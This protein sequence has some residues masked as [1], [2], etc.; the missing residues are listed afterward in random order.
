MNKTA[1]TSIAINPLLAERWSPR[2]FDASAEINN[3]DLLGLLE[4]A[5]WAPSASN[6]QPWRFAVG[7]RG[8]ETFNALFGSLAGFNSAWTP[9]ASALIL[10]AIE[11]VDAEGKPRRWAQYDAGLAASLLTVEAHTRNFH[12]H[13]MAGFDRDK[14]RAALGLNQTTEP[15]MILAIGKVAPAEQLEGPLLERETAPR[16]R[17]SIE[18]ILLRPLP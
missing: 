4:A 16:Q 10:L 12:V 9:R 6:N 17:L 13:T 18:E 8:D 1:E 14:V 15:L 3:T 5:R 11:T 7:K 2:S